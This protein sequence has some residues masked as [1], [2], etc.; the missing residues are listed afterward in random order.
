[1]KKPSVKNVGG[2]KNAP[3]PKT[4]DGMGGPDP[5]PNRP[6]PIKA[7]EI[8][9]KITRGTKAQTQGRKFHKDG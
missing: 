1:M 3:M 9:A 2:I 5:F 8:P 4:Y 6:P 7:P